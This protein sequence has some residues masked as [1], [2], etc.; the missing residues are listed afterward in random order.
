MNFEK[1]FLP[2][3]KDTNH[4]GTILNMGMLGKVQA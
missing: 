2:T 3:G 4:K 1:D